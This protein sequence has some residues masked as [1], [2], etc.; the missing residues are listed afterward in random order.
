MAH[1]AGGL[2][3]FNDA[4]EPAPN[5]FAHLARAFAT[6]RAEVETPGRA[7]LKFV[8]VVLDQ[9][10]PRLTI[11]RALVHLHQK[12]LGTTGKTEKIGCL[13]RADQRA[14]HPVEVAKLDRHR[15][16]SD[17]LTSGET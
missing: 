13:N 2:A 1:R 6:V 4:V 17:S 8:A 11:P 3:A 15:P 9:H 7:P 10:V 16:S 12:W 14:N 5:A